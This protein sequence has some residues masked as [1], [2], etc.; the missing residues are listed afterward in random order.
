MHFFSRSSR[1][2]TPE[3]NNQHS[4][5][6]A[7][8]ESFVEVRGDTDEQYSYSR[9]HMSKDSEGYP[10]WLPQRP[11][12][13]VPASTF[14]G[15]VAGDS[16]A[17]TPG[18][19]EPG[20]FMGMGG[21]KPTPR[22]VRVVSLPQGDEKE[23][24]PTDQTRA[25]HNRVWSRGMASALSPTV[26]SGEPTPLRVQQPRFRSRG[27]NFELLRN[28]SPLF[29]LYFYFYPILVFAHIPLQTFFDFNAVFILIQVSKFP[30]PVAPGVPGSGRNWSLGAAAYIACW[31]TWILVV[32]IYE[33][34]Y[35]FIRRWRIKRPAIYPIYMSAPAFTFASLTSYTNFSFLHHIRFTAFFGEN[36][37]IRDGLA[38]TFYFYSQNLPTVA[39]LLPRGALAVAL[40]LTFSN[41]SPNVVA[42]ADAGINRRDTTF[43]REEDGTLTGYARGVLFANA[44]WTAWR[45]LVLIGS[46]L[47][48]WILSGQVFAGLCGPRYRWEEDDQEKSYAR[49]SVYSDNLSDIDRQSVLPWTW[50]ELTRL[51]IIEA[52]EFCLVSVRPSSNRWGYGKKD[53]TDASALLGNAGLPSPGGFEGIEKLMAA[54]GLGSPTEAEARQQHQR[55]NIMS[56]DFFRT[57][58]E[59]PVPGPSGIRKNGGV[60]P[61]DLAAVIPK[62]I[63]RSSKE[64]SSAGPLL[65]LPYPFAAAGGAAQ[66]SSDDE[67]IPFP[68]S[69]SVPSF[70]ESSSSG[71]RKRSPGQ[72]SSEGEEEEGEKEEEEEEEEE[73]EDTTNGTSEE[74]SS[75]RASGSMSSLGRPVSSR[76]PFQFRQPTRGGASSSSGT[77][78]N[79]TPHSHSNSNSNSHSNG[80]SIASGVSQSTGYRESTDSHSP[81]SVYTSGGSSAASPTSMRDLG[82]PMPP[83]HPQSGTRQG[84]GRARAGTVPSVT[85][86]PSVSMDFPRRRARTR[87]GSEAFAAVPAGVSGIGRSS[88][89]HEPAMYSSDLERD[90]DDEYLDDEGE[91]Y[92]MMEQP[93]PE[94]SQEAAENDDQLGLL[95]PSQGPSPKSSFTALRA[96][97]STL[98]HRRSFGSSSGS[99]SGSN[100]RHNSHSGSSSG[101]SRTNSISVVM[102]GVRSRTQSLLQN[103]ASRSS[104]ELAGRR[105][106][107]NSSIARLEEEPYFSDRTGT[108]SRSGSGS[109]AVMSSG[110]NYTFG[111][112][113]GGHPLRTQWRNPEDQVLEEESQSP[114][115]PQASRDAPRDSPS[116]REEQET[117]AELAPAHPLRPSHSNLSAVTS[118]SVFASAPGY[119]PSL[120][121]SEPTMHGHEETGEPESQRSG[122]LN[123][124]GSEQREAS[125]SATGSSPPDISTAAASFITAPATIDTETTENSGRTASSWR[126]I[127]HMVDRADGTW[128][129]A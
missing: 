87:G 10:S 114:R 94:G 122:G 86:S 97:A 23:H 96:R 99:R 54:V 80:R 111:Q 57:P 58:A 30:D 78:S 48:L 18:P 56:E 129:P 93:E 72:T 45:A 46:W 121:P 75:G 104:L 42:L 2:P 64:P 67:R 41:P 1:Q 127:S 108:H 62:V 68:P 103:V 22:S 6:P 59:S 115:T 13:P 76:Y 81:R 47:G 24:D 7:E 66:V 43:F 109:D 20:F 126:D 31:F 102:T 100:S 106:R 88:P 39:L 21:R 49:A 55:R 37:S 17:P 89:E 8:S 118:P 53:S 83:R 82:I 38:E 101:R 124:P 85:S 16:P 84:R 73:E 69:P 90:V 125:L 61:P 74:P 32:V 19:S 60:T 35:S 15:S 52:Y 77:H 65:K 14:H 79:A 9:T 3:V 33:L 25:G 27:T 26:F 110:E 44:A 11:P 123:I 112:P 51:R 71:R 36:G 40:L 91:E 4:D 28:P 29:R 63:H 113:I 120:P 70:K 107:A 34:V 50:R 12:P 5:S 128:R 95:T 116:D 117:T 105:S 119:P 92:G 98:S